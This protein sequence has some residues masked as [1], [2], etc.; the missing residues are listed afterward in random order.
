MLAARESGRRHR[1]LPR[2]NRFAGT[3]YFALLPDHRWLKRVLH[4]NPCGRT[5]VGR[6]KHSWDSI[7]GNL[8]RFKDWTFMEEGGLGSRF[9]V[10]NASWVF[11][12]LQALMYI[13]SSFTYVPLCLKQAAQSGMQGWQRDDTSSLH[14][15]KWERR[16]KKKKKKKKKQKKNKNIPWWLCSSH[17]YAYVDRTALDSG[18]AEACYIPRLSQMEMCCPASQLHFSRCFRRQGQRI[19]N[20]IS[21]SW[22]IYVCCTDSLHTA[23]SDVWKASALRQRNREGNIVFG[24]KGACFWQATFACQKKIQWQQMH[25]LDYQLGFVLQSIRQN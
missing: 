17:D 20:F 8:C 7:L 6:P 23:C 1:L 18:R 19:P 11:R 15:Y 21:G 25:T 24:R 9:A 22:Q 16:E 5:R 10:F 12:L 2:G 13:G 3:H 4:W 14:G